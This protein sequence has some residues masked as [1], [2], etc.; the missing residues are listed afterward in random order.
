M[1]W[2]FRRIALWGVTGV[3]ALVLLVLIW[4]L[5]VVQRTLMPEK[6]W[7]GRILALEIQVDR[8]RDRA[9][10]C[11]V[12][13]VKLREVSGAGRV[14]ETSPAARDMSRL[15]QTYDEELKRAVDES[16]AAREALRK[17]RS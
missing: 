17:A 1:T 2:T 10:Q 8:L 15:C 11:A 6:Y 7:N 16:I 3:A 14:T 13:V 4:R 9:I 12:A 5:D